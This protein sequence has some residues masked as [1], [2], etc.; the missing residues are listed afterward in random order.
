MIIAIFIVLLYSY[1]LRRRGPPAGL[2]AIVF[3][4]NSGN[5]L[6]SVSD[7]A[8]GSREGVCNYFV[9]CSLSTLLFVIQEDVA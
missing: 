5:L 2:Y 4:C 1:A 6:R 9:T 8:W 7:I 3:S